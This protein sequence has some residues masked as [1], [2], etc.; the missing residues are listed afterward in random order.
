MHDDF[1]IEAFDR[2]CRNAPARRELL[3]LR[4]MSK[5]DRDTA[6]ELEGLEPGLRRRLAPVVT[7]HWHE[8][9]RSSLGPKAE[10]A[11]YS[12]VYDERSDHHLAR[13][14]GRACSCG[15]CRR[16]AG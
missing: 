13:F 1:D 7:R 14:G 8:Q 10:A 16:K 11:L 3:W 4:A 12:K 6:R 9:R 15:E 5:G 2:L